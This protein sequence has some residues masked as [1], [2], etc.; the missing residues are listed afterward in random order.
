MEVL[1]RNE[2]IP[3]SDSVVEELK[4]DFYYKFKKE[5]FNTFVT[6]FICDEN[7]TVI[8]Q[9]SFVSYMNYSDAN[10]VIKYL[11]CNGINGESFELILKNAPRNCKSI[12]FILTSDSQLTGIKNLSVTLR[13]INGE[14][15][16]TFN[17]ITIEEDDTAIILLEFRLSMNKSDWLLTTKSES[18]GKY[19][20]DKIFSDLGVRT[21]A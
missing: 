2:R 14:R 20:I 7:D 11:G 5:S 17:D 4:I 3:L 6:A 19:D 10:S 12:H 8:D 18:L 1:A 13:D 21:I 9:T 16:A 15:I